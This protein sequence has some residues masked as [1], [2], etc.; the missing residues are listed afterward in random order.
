MTILIFLFF[1]GILILVHE[2]GHFIFAR[3]FGA[4]VEEFSIGFPPRIFSKK[5]KE[6][7]YSLGIIIFGGFVKLR[8]E[9]DPNDEK[10]FLFMKPSKKLLIVL[11]G[12]IFNIFL[13]YFLFSLSFFWGYPVPSERIIITG[14]KENSIV[15]D[16]LKIGDEIIKAK[17]GDS[18]YYFKNPQE[19]SKFI[20]ENKSKEI[21]V[22][23][24]RNNS[25]SSFKVSVPKEGLLGIYLSNFEL[26]KT[27]FP[28]NFLLGFEETV[29][30]LFKFLKGLA[31]LF[32]SL[33]SR[34][35]VDFEIVGPVGIYSLFDNV[36]SFGLG[37]IFYFVGVLSLNL[38]VINFLPFPGLDGGR[39]VFIF[40]EV[41][42]SRRVNYE[43]EKIVHQ[44]GIALLFFLITVV[45][46][47][48][49]YKLWVK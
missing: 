30:N 47:K 41:L 38:A 42:T 13:A 28:L 40:Y 21:E 7:V 25:E 26:K 10:G 27:G 39:A 12:V 8:G 34:E 44:I 6:T 43:K 14:I 15:K 5:I 3:R 1:L 32:S 4:I 29:Q 31:L 45:T 2:L 11:G 17:L 16:Y 35:K 19:F 24:L 48:D 20:R 49:I 22:F 36:K 33:V 23:Y 18:F 37:Y 9:E 46:L